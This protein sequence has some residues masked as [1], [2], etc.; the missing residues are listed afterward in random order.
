MIRYRHITTKKVTACVSLST[1]PLK[2]ARGIGEI[3]NRR[4]LSGGSIDS[5]LMA[6]CASMRDIP[7]IFRRLM[8]CVSGVA[9]VELALFLPLMAMLLAALGNLGL[10]FQAKIQVN[11]A[12]SSA[13][14]YAFEKGQGL[15]SSRIPGFDADIRTVIQAMLPTLGTFTI[16]LKYNDSQSPSDF[17]EYYCIRQGNVPIFIRSGSQQSECSNGIKSAKYIL[18]EISGKISIILPLADVF[19]ENLA[20]SDSVYVRVE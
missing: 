10:A 5:L 15:T 11:N 9:A 8:L 12:L 1:L 19:G 2:H 13:A 16:N 4:S 6:V 3:A 7:Q 18:I 14:Y 17:N 20:V